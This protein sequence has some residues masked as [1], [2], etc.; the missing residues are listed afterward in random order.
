LE[1]RSHS[2]P[3]RAAWHI[4]P[5]EQTLIVT[6]GLGLAQKEGGT[7]KE[8]WPGDVV[9]ITAGVKHW[10]KASPTTS[11]T[12]IAIQEKLDGKAAEWLEKVSDEQYDK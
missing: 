1:P 2:S 12:H 11:M 8:I 7:A 3:A 9:W 10:H 4:H 5:L 6:A